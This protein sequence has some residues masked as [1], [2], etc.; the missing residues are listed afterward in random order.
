[1]ILAYISI[2]LA[3]V[4]LAFCTSYMAVIIEEQIR[5]WRNKRAMKQ[6]DD[7]PPFAF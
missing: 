3:V 5:T 1:M 7:E 4:T 6:R 2:F